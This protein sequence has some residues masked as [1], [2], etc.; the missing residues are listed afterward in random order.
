MRDQLTLGESDVT[1][2]M[3]ER[4]LETAGIAAAVHAL[5]AG[6]STPME[7]A[8]LSEGE[9]HL[10]GFARAIVYDP[11]I[12]LLD[13]CT[14]HLDSGTEALLLA[15]IGRMAEGRAVLSIAHRWS[16]AT[17]ETRK[18]MLGGVE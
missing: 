18:I 16:A 9:R 11:R 2:A 14:A 10:L 1:D 5:P 15:A 7:A 17:A 3:I 4:A 8:G 13:E 6:L 12:L